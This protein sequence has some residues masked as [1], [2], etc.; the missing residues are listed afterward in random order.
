VL[1]SLRTIR[2]SVVWIEERRMNQLKVTG[3]LSRPC[4]PFGQP[5]APSVPHDALR[6]LGSGRAS[7]PV[8]AAAGNAQT[9]RSAPSARKAYPACRRIE[10]LRGANTE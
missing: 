9:R 10:E 5:T 3:M 4:A 1:P 7:G 8:A 6:I 2:K